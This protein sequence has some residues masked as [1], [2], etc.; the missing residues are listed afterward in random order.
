M[1]AAGLV[2]ITPDVEEN[3]ERRLKMHI[4]DAHASLHHYW[5]IYRG[6]RGAGGIPCSNIQSTWL[7][8][9]SPTP[10]VDGWGQAMWDAEKKEARHRDKSEEERAGPGDKTRGAGR[11]INVDAERHTHTTRSSSIGLRSWCS[12]S[13]ASAGSSFFPVLPNWYSQYVTEKENPEK[14]VIILLFLIKKM[15]SLNAACL[16]SLLFN[17]VNKKGEE[18][19]YRKTTGHPPCW[20]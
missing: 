13:T 6:R 2:R 14:I 17:I 8:W 9:E 11:R 1:G 16:F 19:Q 18:K 10:P 4:R 7:N 5:G 12:V 15:I 3:L 20:Y